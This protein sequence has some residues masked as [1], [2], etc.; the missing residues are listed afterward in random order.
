[1]VVV[2]I[3]KK[4]DNSIPEFKNEDE[5]RDYL[6]KITL[7]IVVNLK[8]MA[9]KKG[10]VRKAPI[11]NAKNSQYRV[12]LESIKI[13]NTIL[14]D[15]EINILS[16]KIKNLEKFGLVGVNENNLDGDLFELSPEIKR[17]LEQFKL[18]HE[19]L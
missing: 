14:K 13:L 15:K 5:L 18:I 3:V 11:V 1:M 17:E 6:I 8:D 2:D 16:Q 19:E 10:N 7:E 9:L 12:A 4:N